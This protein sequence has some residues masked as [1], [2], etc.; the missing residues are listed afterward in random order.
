MAKLIYQVTM[1]V[2]RYG[3]EFWTAAS[4]HVLNAKAVYGV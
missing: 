4:P 3:S 2:T 1:F